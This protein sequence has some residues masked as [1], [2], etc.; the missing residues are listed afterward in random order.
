MTSFCKHLNGCNS[1]VVQTFYNK[2]NIIILIFSIIATLSI[3]TRRKYIKTLIAKICS[4]HDILLAFWFSAKS[5]WIIK[6]VSEKRSINF[7]MGNNL[8]SFIDVLFQRFDVFFKYFDRI[9]ECSNYFR[10]SFIFDRLPTLKCCLNDVVS[11]T[12]ATSFA[13]NFRPGWIK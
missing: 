7:P 3:A 10:F 12:T 2:D 9:F 1:I 5:L 6:V 4:L 8:P 11:R 13:T